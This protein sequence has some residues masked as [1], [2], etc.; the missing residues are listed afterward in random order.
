MST[1]L[2]RRRVYGPL[3]HAVR[4]AVAPCGPFFLPRIRL[5]SSQEWIRLRDAAIKQFPNEVLARGE[6]MRR[7]AMSGVAALKNLSEQDR[8]RLQHQ[9]QSTM[10]VPGSEGDNGGSPW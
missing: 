5:L 6:I 9:H 4:L 1:T 7:Y 2:N 3:G 10:T 8:A